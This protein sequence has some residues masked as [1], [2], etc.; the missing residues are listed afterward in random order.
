ML[1]APSL[2]GTRNAA[3]SDGEVAA[4]SH[5]YYWTKMALCS[6]RSASRLAR[7]KSRDGLPFGPV[8]AVGEMHP[9][10]V[11]PEKTAVQ[12]QMGRSNGA[13]G[14]QEPT[15]AEWSS[16]PREGT[17][18]RCASPSYCQACF[19]VSGLVT[20]SGPEISRSISGLFP[21]HCIRTLAFLGWLS[22]YTTCIATRQAQRQHDQDSGELQLGWGKVIAGCLGAGTCVVVR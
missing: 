16:G 7:A 9:H 3:G 13:A 2:R 11:T 14:R 12:A 6:G 10:L 5:F 1:S 22:L 21:F 18:T 4:Q 19:R 15:A 8:L 17:V 20:L